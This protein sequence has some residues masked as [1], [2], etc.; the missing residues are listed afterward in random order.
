MLIERMMMD[1]KKHR[2]Y[3]FRKESIYFKI[4]WK[5]RLRASQIFR[6]FTFIHWTWWSFAIL[7][8]GMTQKLPLLSR[9]YKIF[10]RLMQ[11]IGLITILLM[12][13]WLILRFLTSMF[14][15]FMAWNTAISAIEL[16]S[17]VGNTVISSSFVLIC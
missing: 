3:P 4:L 2:N 9:Y 6:G 11:W 16:Q 7:L 15:Q 5:K 13:K 12:R 10:K 17:N 14:W 8:S 1:S